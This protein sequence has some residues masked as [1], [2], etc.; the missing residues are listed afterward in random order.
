MI[1]DGKR[2]QF[3]INNTMFTLDIQTDRPVQPV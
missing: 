3:I 1:N 2:K